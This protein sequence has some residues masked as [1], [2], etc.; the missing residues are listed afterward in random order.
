MVWVFA[1]ATSWLVPTYI[2][3][4]RLASTIGEEYAIRSESIFYLVKNNVVCVCIFLLLEA[5]KWQ[6]KKLI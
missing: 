3:Q 5:D 6:H 4:H 1:H 2:Q